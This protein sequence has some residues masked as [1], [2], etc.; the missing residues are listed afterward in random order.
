MERIIK[1][2][3]NHAAVETYYFDGDKKDI[4]VIVNT[5]TYGQ[6][7]ITEE[8]SKLTIGLDSINAYDKAEEAAAQQE[9]ID[10]LMEIQTKMNGVADV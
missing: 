1:I 10:E 3:N 6:N 5:E 8:L 2:A 4:E 7:R 9:K